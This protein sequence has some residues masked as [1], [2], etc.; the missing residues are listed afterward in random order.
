MPS[1]PPELHE[2]WCNAGPYY[3][4][5]DRNALAF[6]AGRGIKEIKNGF[7]QIPKSRV[8]DAEECNALDYLFMEWDFAM[9][10]V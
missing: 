2:K 9:V 6:L 1:G 7:F 10:R 5:G 3:G 8:L 4:H